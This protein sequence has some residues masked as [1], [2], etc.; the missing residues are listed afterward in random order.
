[1]SKKYACDLPFHHMAIQP[2][3]KIRP[4]C[5]FRD[6]ESP[7]DL[8]ISHPDPFNH[9]FMKFVRQMMLEDTPV[10]GCRSCYKDEAI[11]GYSMRQEVNE[12]KTFGL[13]FERDIRGKVEKLTN[14]DLALSNVCNNRCRM[15]GPWLSTNWY[16]D[17]KKLGMDIP[18]GVVAKNSVI[19]D[20]DLSD[21]RFIKLIGGEPLMEQEKFIRVLKKCD[22]PKLSILLVTNA[23]L[24]PNKDLLDLFHQCQHIDTHLS[25]DAYGTLNNTL[26]KGSD[27]NQIDK[28]VDWYCENLH[29]SK[30]FATSI[31]SVVSIYNCNLVDKMIEYKKSKGVYSKFDLVDGP[32]WMMPR[33]LPDAAKIELELLLVKQKSKYQEHIFDALLDEISKPGD[34]K[35]FIE[36]D[37]KLNTLRNDNWHKDNTWLSEAIKCI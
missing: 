35:L 1:M 24:L 29:G 2:N 20:Y 25:I 17:A 31:D 11:T 33:N 22:L 12:S 36:M 21:L 30:Q 9:P 6:E 26:R 14:I 18:K 8:N 13:P 3:G 32:D 15:C 19:D 23:T 27:W 34:T 4:C 10:E 37:Q 5:Y 7:D 16:S 28:N